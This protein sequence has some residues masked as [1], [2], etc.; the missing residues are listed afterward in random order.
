[1]EESTCPRKAFL[2]YSGTPVPLQSPTNSVIAPPPPNLSQSTDRL[3]TNR[4]NKAGIFINKKYTCAREA[5]TKLFNIRNN[6]PSSYACKPKSRGNLKGRKLS[7][8]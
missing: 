5:F 1:M 4:T 6:L 3:G 7:E 2:K 8:M